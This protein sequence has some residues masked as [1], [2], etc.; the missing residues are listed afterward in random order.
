MINV[1]KTGDNHFVVSENQ[2]WVPGIYETAEIAEKAPSM[3]DEEIITL[4]GP[5]Y[6]IDGLN[7]PVNADDMFHALEAAQE[8]RLKSYSG[9]FA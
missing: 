3:S 1:Q 9:E 8:M 7:R 6:Q 5:I 2:M 4:L